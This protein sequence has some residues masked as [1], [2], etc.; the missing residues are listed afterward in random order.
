LVKL[1]KSTAFHPRGRAARRRIVDKPQE[2]CGLG[3]A[4]APLEEL[5]GGL[6]GADLFSDRHG[7]PLVQRHP[8]F[9]RESRGGGLDRAGELE[10]ISRLAHRRTS[11]KTSAGSR[12]DTPN[13][14]AGAKSFTL[15][16]MFPQNNCRTS[17]QDID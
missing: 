12:T 10:G 8:V 11:F 3:L 14:A 9:L 1:V 17:L 4:R 7:D 5:R 15:N 2:I 6:D 16:R 13:R